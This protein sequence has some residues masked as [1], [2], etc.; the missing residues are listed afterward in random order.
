[1]ELNAVNRVFLVLDTHDLSVICNGC[2]LET[3]RDSVAVSGKRVIAGYLR[4]VTDALEQRQY[5]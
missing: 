5:E 1:M 4:A 2:Y 3:L